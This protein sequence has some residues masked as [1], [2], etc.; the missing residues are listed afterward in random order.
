ME[1]ILRTDI[2][3]LGKAG[4]VVKVRDGFARNYLI[5]KGLAIPANQRTL[6]ALE[7]Q[8]KIFLAKAERERKKMQTIAEKLKDMELTIYRKTIEEDRIFG[9]V[10]ALDLLNLL[11]EKGIGID[12]KQ[13]LLEEPIKR[14]GSYEIPIK[15]ASDLIVSLKLEVLEE[16]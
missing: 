11:K 5:P 7:N 12:K 2:P 3:K 13:I 9:S 14:L 15:L 8:R 16:R 4:E 6:K 10:S 1:V